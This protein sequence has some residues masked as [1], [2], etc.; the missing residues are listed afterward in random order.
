MRTQAGGADHLP[1]I[2]GAYACVGG[3]V[4]ECECGCLLTLQL[5]WLLVG[6]CGLLVVCWWWC[7]DSSFPL[8]GWEA[9]CG[10]RGSQGALRFHDASHILYS[11]LSL[12]YS[13]YASRERLQQATITPCARTITTITAITSMYH[14]CVKIRL[15]RRSMMPVG[16]SRL[17]FTHSDASR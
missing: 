15:C 1:L 9:G 4:Q 10:V 14:H 12:L 7:E 17:N 13:L 5:L 2:Q 16:M 8:Q 6:R 11:T 3:G